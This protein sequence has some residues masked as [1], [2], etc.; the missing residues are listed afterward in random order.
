MMRVEG[1]SESLDVLLACF[2]R[3]Q[4]WGCHQESM[5]DQERQLA[6]SSKN[7]SA[8]PNASSKSHF[9]NKDKGGWL[10]SASCFASAFACASCGPWIFPQEIMPL[11]FSKE[12]SESRNHQPTRAIGVDSRRVPT[13]PQPT[14]RV[15]FGGSFHPTV[16]HLL[17]VRDDCKRAS[18]HGPEPAVPTQQTRRHRPRLLGRHEDFSRTFLTLEGGPMSQERPSGNSNTEH[19]TKPNHPP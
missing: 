13:H 7:P 5:A 16:L 19:R 2:C 9:S 1:C 4:P 8:C 3:L 12:R 14:Y 6:G 17:S 15:G 10:V 11:M 18:A